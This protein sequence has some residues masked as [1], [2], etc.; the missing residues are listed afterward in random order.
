MFAISGEFATQTC[1]QG[2]FGD[3]MGSD[4]FGAHILVHAPKPDLE[5]AIARI[6]YVEFNHVGQAFRLGRYPIHLHLNGD[7]KSSY[8]RGCGLHQTF[9]RAVN[10]H[11][12]H[13]LVVEHNVIYN[14]MGGSFFLEDGIETGNTFQ[15]NLATFVR[16]TSS[17]LNDD[18]TPACFWV[19]NPNNTIRHNAAAGGTHF[20]FWYRMHEHPDG[21]SFDPNICPRHV[22]LGTFE[23]NTAH[24]MGWFGLWIFQE[25]HP[26][27]DGSCSTTADHEVAIFK[28]LTVWNCEKG[29]EAV[30]VGALQFHKFIMVHNEKAGYEGK[31]IKDSPQY[32]EATSYAVKDSIM[33]AN[34]PGLT[35][36]TGQKN[37]CTIGGIVLPYGNGMYGINIEFYN[38]DRANCNAFTYTKIDGT[39]SI[40]CGGYTYR[41]KQISFNSSPNRGK[42]DWKWQAVMVDEDGSLTGGAPGSQVTPTTT[43]LPPS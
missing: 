32:D 13:N 38:F 22:P 29:A 21:P 7:M 25:Y 15:Y 40:W 5:L 11:K 27:K 14:V 23:N 28:T 33:V 2:R 39:C 42:F 24:S 12:T 6:E 10:V 37:Y 26:R 43:T 31:L 9:N 1:F 17:L 19:T 3:E 16:A 30:N 41:F 36:I 34:S 20:G 18:I 35:A 4:Q 8:V